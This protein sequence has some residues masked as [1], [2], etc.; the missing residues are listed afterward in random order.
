MA[1]HE[2]KSLVI[3]GENQVLPPVTKSSMIEVLHIP[4]IFLLSKSY[5]W[6]FQ[7]EW[8]ENIKLKIS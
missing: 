4:P 7:V 5:K 3:Y 1:F 2:P 8:V 6:L